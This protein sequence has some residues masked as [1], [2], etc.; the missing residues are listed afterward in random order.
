[1]KPITD[2][3]VV[4]AVSR[5]ADLFSEVYQS[6]DSDQFA[7]LAQLVFEKTEPG[8]IVE[9]DKAVTLISESGIE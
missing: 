7:A 8:E 9:Q 3:D 5:A 4:N 2:A 1:M 6:D